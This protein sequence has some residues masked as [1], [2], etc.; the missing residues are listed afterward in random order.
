MQ[1]SIVA[2][3][4]IGKERELKYLLEKYWRKEISAATLEKEAAALRQVHWQNQ[5]DG[6]L[7]Y[8]TINDFSLYDTVLDTA[9]LF[10]IIP[11]RYRRLGLSALDTYFAL[12]RGYRDE[13][14]TVAPLAMKK[15]FN[16]NYHYIVPEFSD[17]CD[18]KL[19][20][21][22]PLAQY[23]ETASYQLKKKL[24]LLGP[25]TLLKLSAYNGSKGP[26]TYVPALIRAYLEFF[27]C[28]QQEKVELLQL[29]EPAL[30]LDLQQEDLNLLKKL[31]SELLAGKGKLQILLQTYFG[32]VRDCYDDLIKLDFDA[33]GLDFVE[34]EKTLQLVSSTPFPTD[35]I[36]FAGIVNGRNVWRNSY[37]TSL[38]LI[39]N[40]QLQGIN[41]VLQSSC[42]LQHVPYSLTGEK[43][44]PPALKEKLAFG[45]EKIRELLLLKELAT[46]DPA[47]DS[48]AVTP[49]VNTAKNQVKLLPLQAKAT[50]EQRAKLQQQCLNL[51]LLPTT[52]IGSF[53][54]SQAVRQNRRR[55][56]KQLLKLCDYEK[57]NYAEIKKCIRFQEEIGL[58]VLV[59]GEFERNDMVEFFAQ[60]LSGFVVTQNAWIQSYGSR[61]VKPPIIVD[62]IKYRQAMTVKWIKYAQSLTTKPVKAVLTGPT[63][64]VNWSFNREDIPAQNSILQLAAALKNEV[65]AL[66][67][68]GSK[69]IQIDEPAL[70]EKLPLRKADQA[71]YLETAVNAFQFLHNSCRPETMIQT[72]IC[73]SD[74]TDIIPWL[75]KLD[76]DVIL[77]EASRTSQSCLQNPAFLQLNAAL[78]LGVYDVHSECIPSVAELLTAIKQRLAV[79]PAAALWV[80]PDCGLKTRTYKELA[81]SLKNMVTACSRMRQMLSLPE[82]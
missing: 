16:T 5:V 6:S 10:N 54:K 72:H 79:I 35:K 2:Y 19:V 30:T 21:Q 52:T 8:L 73:Y 53:P 82:R 13:K 45:E 31:Y 43:N 3:P 47:A 28:C 34:G 41:L 55:Y 68:S 14:G 81:P 11:T 60:Q 12:A 24:L 15:W 46:A 7:D 70:R 64:I 78:S 77:L 40:L 36:L 50:Y 65:T 25:F 4:H 38:N 63:T 66:E 27:R 74:Y 75:D 9:C 42:S 51:P 67:K 48:T 23:R 61:C 37:T 32:D 29:D 18:I 62:D 71:A 20:S 17:D 33:L 76:A 44:L 56:N 49:T 59:H 1:T 39:K 26:A 80:A 57:F 69:I 22:T 58:D